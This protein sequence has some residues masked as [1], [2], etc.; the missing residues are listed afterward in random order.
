MTREDTR[1]IERLEEQYEGLDGKLD[2]ITREASV[3][4][5]TMGRIEE[6]IKTVFRHYP[7]RKDVDDE[8]AKACKKVSLPPPGRSG[9]WMDSPTLRWIILLI[10]SLI[11]G[12]SS[13]AIIK[14]ITGPEM[15]PAVNSGGNTGSNK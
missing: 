7:T 5:E 1:R 9:I 2:G 13:G 8:I 4:R 10:G 12:G 11:A 14:K 3:T 15:V 6:Q